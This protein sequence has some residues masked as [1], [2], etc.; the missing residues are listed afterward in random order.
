MDGE[1]KMKIQARQLRCG[2][3][4]RSNPPLSIVAIKREGLRVTVTDDNGRTLCY[5]MSEQIGVERHSGAGASD[6][7]GHLGDGDEV[8]HVRSMS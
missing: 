8:N 7:I 1:L 6:E 2:D 5:L 4:I 3:T